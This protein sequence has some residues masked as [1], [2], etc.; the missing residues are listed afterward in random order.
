MSARA[1]F[2]ALALASCGGASPPSAASLDVAI[3]MYDQTARQL[4]TVNDGDTVDLVFPPQGGFVMFVGVKVRGL[5][6]PNVRLEASLLDTNGTSLASDTRQLT[7]HPASN[8]A[9]LW[10]PDLSSYVDV[11]N[12][13][14]CPSYDNV[15]RF[16]RPYQLE[17][18]VTE[19]STQRTGKTRRLVVPACRQTDVSLQQRCRCLCAANYTDGKCS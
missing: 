4:T 12:I 17:C 2:A 6:S 15:D 10:L 3:T 8:D 5:S 11:A 18:S 16:G 19:L 7:L 13:T 9:T 1:A 14:V